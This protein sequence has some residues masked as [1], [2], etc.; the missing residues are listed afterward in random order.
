MCPVWF[1]WDRKKLT[2]LDW[3]QRR[4]KAEVKVLLKSLGHD[5]MLG[6]GWVEEHRALRMPG[7]LRKKQAIC[8]LPREPILETAK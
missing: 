5:A 2:H 7:V 4:E 6:F 1:S 8:P 3:V